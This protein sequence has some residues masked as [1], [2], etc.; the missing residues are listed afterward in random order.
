MTCRE[1]VD[2]IT[3][4]L[5]G[6]LPE[7]ERRR[8]E[9]H[10]AGCPWCVAYVEQMRVTVRLTGRL[11]EE[12]VPPATREALVAAFRHWKSGRG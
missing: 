11:A 4:Y 5:E 3:D 8:L 2:L 7:P 9:A 6:A 1:V 10:L 12:A